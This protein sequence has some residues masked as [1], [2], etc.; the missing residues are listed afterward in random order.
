MQSTIYIGADKIE[1][2]NGTSMVVNADTISED[3]NNEDMNNTP[4][5]KRWGLHTPPGI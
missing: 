2:K 4:T 3:M 5:T 1:L